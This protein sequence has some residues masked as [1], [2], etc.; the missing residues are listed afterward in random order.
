MATTQRTK[1]TEAEFSGGWTRQI[2]RTH[3]VAS[4]RREGGYK[5][6]G[7]GGPKRRIPNVYW[8][9]ATGNATG[10]ADEGPLLKLDPFFVSFIC[11]TL[12]VMGD[13]G[14]DTEESRRIPDACAPSEG[15]RVCGGVTA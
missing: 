7:N 15:L 1:T 6:R 8:D 4:T 11:A 14:V 3:S 12:T 2:T 9:D 5:G 10:T 13:F